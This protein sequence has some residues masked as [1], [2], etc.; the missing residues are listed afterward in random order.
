MAKDAIESGRLPP[1]PPDRKSDCP[2]DGA[3]C[4]V[5]LL[6]MSPQARGYEL[7]F[8]QD[9]RRP[10]THFMHIPCFAAWETQSRG[11][12]RRAN[13]GRMTRKREATGSVNGH[14]RGKGP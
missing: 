2:G 4:T 8:V 14:D 5:C 3:S 12:G 6:P 11:S 10:A 7:E 13:Q 9:G 1:R